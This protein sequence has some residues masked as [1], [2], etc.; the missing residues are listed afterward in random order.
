MDNIP[1]L[2]QNLKEGGL[3]SKDLA[4]IPLN[5]RTW[6]KWNL[7][8]LWVGM[9]VC[10][11]T[12]MLASFMIKSGM[13]WQASLII[14]F[15]A[16]LVITIPMVLNGHAGV[17]YGI[18]F[19]VIGRAAF[20]IRGIHIP[21][22][23]RGLVACGWFGIQTWIGGLAIYSI[24]M[25]IMGESYFM[26]E[27]TYGKFIAFGVFWVINIYFIWKGTESIKWLED[28]SAPILLITGILLIGWGMSEGNGFSNVLA[29]GKQLQ[30]PTAE[31]VHSGDNFSVKI[32]PLHNINDSLKATQYWV[33]FPYNHRDSTTDWMNLTKDTKEFIL[34]SV[35]SEDILVGKL[36]WVNVQFRA[37]KPK[38]DIFQTRL[39]YKTYYSSSYIQ[40]H[41]SDKPAASVWWNYI[42]WFTAMVG[43][44][45]TMSISIS[46]ITRYSKSQKDQVLG[47]FIGLP[48]TMMFYSFIGIF[49]T[50]AAVVAFKDVLISEDAPWDPVRLMSKFQSPIVIILAQIAMI[51]ATLS[52][53]IAANIIA[54]A[55]TLANM[56]PKQISFRVGG[57]IAGLIGVAVCPWI[58]MNE[59]S[60]YLMLISGLL[61]PVLGI[62]LCDY[63]IIRKKTLN[64]LELFNKNG[65]Y[66]YSAG[67]NLSALFSMTVGV[68]CALV[69]YLVPSVRFLFSLSWFTG[70]IISFGLYYILM[71]KNALRHG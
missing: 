62:M 51:I 55:F 42:L 4:P 53:N 17:K 5:K 28:Y 66:K 2:S 70:F 46:D 58:L 60:G 9:A 36:K 39:A 43:F 16:N 19:P 30:N 27:L 69:G 49:V 3:Y 1:E 44:W 32:N 65:I 21:A 7:A 33:S 8:A 20:G 31:L 35:S 56:F 48:G 37:P 68:L 71:K 13:S 34:P 15:L 47:Q 26:N 59:I 18:P 64:V 23:V 6:N 50:C 24:Y 25:T 22:A 52:T 12:Y 38:N 61:G 57:V 29:Q 41:Y 54:P 11:P 40:L 67:F 14:I 10:I 45:A 63:F